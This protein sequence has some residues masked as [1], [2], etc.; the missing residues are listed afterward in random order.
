MYLPTVVKQLTLGLHLIEEGVPHL[1]GRHVI[2]TRKY[3]TDDVIVQYFPL[4]SMSV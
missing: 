1:K 2:V 4:D 3:F